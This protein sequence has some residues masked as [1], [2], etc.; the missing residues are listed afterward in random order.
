LSD[1]TLTSMTMFLNKAIISK[2]PF[3]II[4]LDHVRGDEFLHPNN[5]SVWLNRKSLFSGK[6]LYSFTK[7]KMDSGEAQTELTA[8]R[9]YCRN[10]LEQTLDLR[11]PS[12]SHGIKHEYTTISNVYGPGIGEKV[13]QVHFKYDP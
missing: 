3:V 2:P 10:V 13:E 8:F 11:I 9:S 1:S 6:F 5:E 7:A 4:T 12:L